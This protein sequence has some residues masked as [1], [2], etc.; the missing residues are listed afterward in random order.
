MKVVMLIFLILCSSLAYVNCQNIGDMYN[1]SIEQVTN[2]TQINVPLSI[3]IDSNSSS[4]NIVCSVTTTWNN[5]VI[6]DYIQGRERYSTQCVDK[7]DFLYSSMLDKDELIMHDGKLRYQ[8]NLGFD[9]YQVGET[10]ELLLE[11]GSEIC[12][13]YAFDVIPARVPFSTTVF[14]SIWSWAT[15]PLG[16]VYTLVIIIILSILLRGYIKEVGLNAVNK[17]L[18]GRQ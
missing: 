13:K 12:Y 9:K 2:I 3:L 17:I 15:D 18:R 6:L 16:W 10:Y 14:N 8:L 4:S 11:C 1:I 5:S 7:P